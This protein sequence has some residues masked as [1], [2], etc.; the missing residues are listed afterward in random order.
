[1]TLSQLDEP[2]RSQVANLT[3][4]ASY[5]FVTYQ[6][7]VTSTA[8]YFNSY[9]NAT[10]FRGIVEHILHDYDTVTWSE[11]RLPKYMHGNIRYVQVL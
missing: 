10:S 4:D 1:M 7:D 8:T 3:A 9:E 11:G 5:W 2:L 6:F